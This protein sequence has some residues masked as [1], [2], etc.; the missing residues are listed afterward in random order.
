M[1]RYWH[2]LHEQPVLRRLTLIQLLSYF[3]AWFTNVAIYTLLLKLD[4]SPTV[5]ALTAVMHFL[6]GVIQAPFTGVLI[7][8]FV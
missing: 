7:D 1:N 2:L 8:R 5:I 6:P 4:V 3:G